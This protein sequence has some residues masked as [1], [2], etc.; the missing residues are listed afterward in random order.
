M[1]NGFF[2]RGKFNWGKETLYWSAHH[3]FHNGRQKGKGYSSYETKAKANAEVKKLRAVYDKSVT[4]EVLPDSELPFIK[5]QHVEFKRLFNRAARLVVGTGRSGAKFL[6]DNLSV[7]VDKAQILMKRLCEQQILG[8][9]YCKKGADFWQK[10]YDVPRR[11][12]SISPSELEK[13]LK[14]IHKHKLL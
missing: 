6:M 11:V 3:S 5:K 9:P 12:K 13:K 10:A 7:P 4:F 2:I 14:F 8:E 1:A